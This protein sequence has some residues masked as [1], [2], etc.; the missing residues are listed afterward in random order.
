MSAGN[1]VAPGLMVLHGNRLEELR[2]VLVA[3]LRR[4]P[5]R[6]LEDEWVLVQSNGIAQWFRLALARAVEDGGLGIAAAVNVQ[7]PGRFLWVAYR[8][9]LGKDAVPPESPFDKSRLVWR[10]MRL[11]PSLAGE[12]G[13]APLA[14]FLGSDGDARKCH[15]LAERLA[16]L[17]DGYQVYRADWLD[18]WAAGRDV[19][20]DARGAA[21]AMAEG[22]RWQAL[23]WRRLLEDVGP[24]EADGHRA[25]VHERFLRAVAAASE[26]PS[27]LP[28]RIVVFGMST[29]PRQTLEALSAL[30]RWSQVVLVVMNP[31]RHYWADIVDDRELLRAERRRQEAKPGMPALP[32]DADMHLYANPLL[33]AWG[34]QGRDYIRLLDEFDHP[35]SYRERFTA[36]DQRIDL[37]AEPASD[38]LLG[39]VQAA[40]LDLEPLP[41]EPR[42]VATDDTSIVFHLAHGPQREVE[43]LHD[44][45]LARFEASADRGDPILPRDVIV[46]VPDIETYGPHI[47]AVFGRVPRDDPRFI[48]FSVA[49]RA[50]R[51]TVPLVMALDMLMGMTESRFAA[52]EM[53]DLLDVPSVR[54]RFGLK[55][56]HL[57]LLHRWI[58][59]AGIR[60]GL[61][62]AQRG[63]LGLPA[64]GQNTWT[65]GL[66][67]MLL[68]YAVGAG[69][70]WGDIEPFDEVGGLDAALVGPLADLLDAL[71][72]H[73]RHMADPAPPTVWATRLRQL[74]D[75]FFDRSDAD[76]AK[77]VER[78][79]DALDVWEGACAEAAFDEALPVD[80]VRE[81]WLGQFDD[82]GLSKRFLAGAVS[83]GTL[84]P[85]RAIPFRV[86]CLLGMNDGDYPRARPPMDFDLMSR[87]G[88]W[89]P[90]DRSRR[91]DDRYLFLEALLSARDA[92]HI[93]WVA[94]SARDNSERA[95]SVLVGQLRDYLATAWRASSVGETLLNRLSV[96]HPLQPFSRAYFREGDAR[97][98][99]YASEWRQAHD[100]APHADH[101]ELPALAVE[102]PVGLAVLRRFLRHP[103]REFFQARLGVRFELAD[104][105]GDD[106]EPFAVDALGRF[107]MTDTL[108]R[109]ALHDERDATGAIDVAASRLQRS[110]LLPMGAFAA[111]VRRDLTAAAS[112]V[113]GRFVTE[114]R[115]WPVDAGKRE[116]RVEVDG[117]VIEDWLADLRAN[118]QGDLASFLLSPSNVLDVDG[119]PRAHRLVMPW[120]DHL[121]AQ[122]AGLAVETR[123]VG[124]DA[125]I[126]LAPVPLDPA[127]TMLHT[128]V[129]A[130][131]EGMRTPLP[132]AAR[133][134]IAALSAPEDG[135]LQAAR[136]AYDGVHD[137]ARG[138]VDGDPYLT[139]AWPNFDALAQAGFSGWL[140]PYRDLLGL[141]RV[142]RS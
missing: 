14:A 77:L 68:G 128:L 22:D 57:P 106:L 142:D 48:P 79:L 56:D 118:A 24:G 42:P 3:W 18:D 90:G 137:R 44:Q 51:G 72:R 53:A 76:D 98:F 80:V 35:E 140:Q 12:D 17:Y 123:Y 130:W 88:A 108:L 105:A 41:A 54:R 136:T 15:Q 116:I 64:L 125:T 37:F 61:D 107:G 26:R 89:R 58:E 46:M 38:T 83:F 10:L 2:D 110:G 111:P 63:S 101:V 117:V 131:R 32:S 112:A 16:D 55:E 103:V 29:L 104:V 60:W 69:E 34:K 127:T 36:W 27:A 8:A 96:E 49:D 62:A 65:F 135:A 86:V 66:R 115:A 13:F 94:R 141:L 5:L 81:A 84:M 92:L 67:R 6:P 52:G 85:M 39:Q 102:R 73:W 9:V 97:L 78:L 120:I 43:I 1:D 50:A 133:T 126:V 91:E 100:A 121:V 113:F 71:G 20:R 28:R 25:A 109:A 74:L 132:V 82:A 87:A 124:P 122:A 47:D 45:L 99:T 70:A 134:A 23:L 119:S 33:A 40:I 30:A 31:C 95:P 138:E 21:P 19:L 93:G 4:A 59:G 11:L 139:R 75:D 114:R 7:L 129:N